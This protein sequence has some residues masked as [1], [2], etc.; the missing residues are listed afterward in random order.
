MVACGLNWWWCGEAWRGMAW[1]GVAWC[2]VV[3]CC[4]VLCGMVW[5]TPVSASKSRIALPINPDAVVRPSPKDSS[6]VRSS[7]M[8]TVDCTSDCRAEARGKYLSHP[9]PIR[10]N[11][12]RFTSQLTP[13]HPHTHPTPTHSTILHPSPIQPNRS[14]QLRLSPGG[15]VSRHAIPSHAKPHD[16]TPSHTMPRRTPPTLSQTTPRQ[17]TRCH[18][19]PLPVCPEAH[20]ATRYQFPP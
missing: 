9:K 15:L 12:T 5:Y 8:F 10:P 2:C 14:N 3:L 7:S 19:M 4:V 1:R 11:A 16:A 6:T 20:D 18:T 17:V 13:P